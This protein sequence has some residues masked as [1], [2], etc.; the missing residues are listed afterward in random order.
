MIAVNVF[1]IALC[2][3]EAVLYFRIE[4]EVMVCCGDEG[5]PGEDQF[6]WVDGLV[7]NGD[8]DGYILGLLGEYVGHAIFELVTILNVWGEVGFRVFW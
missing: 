7:S 3:P 5:Y 2:L 1:C 8:C 6:C 4:I